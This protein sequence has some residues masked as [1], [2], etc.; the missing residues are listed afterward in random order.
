MGQQLVDTQRS[1]RELRIAHT[2]FLF[3]N[4]RELRIAPSLRPRLAVPRRCRVLWCLRLTLRPTVAPGAAAV[5]G[6]ARRRDKDLVAATRSLW[7]LVR[8]CSSPR[9]VSPRGRKRRVYPAPTDPGVVYRSVIPAVRN[10]SRCKPGVQVSA[11]VSPQLSPLLSSPQPPTASSPDPL[12]PR[13]GL[14]ETAL[15]SSDTSPDLS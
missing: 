11:A 3:H 6:S 14:L 10:R 2:R 5:D 1:L 4:P 9:R 7:R 15:K 8:W 13:A 12:R